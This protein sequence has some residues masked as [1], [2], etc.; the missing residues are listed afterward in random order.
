[1]GNRRVVGISGQVKQTYGDKGV[2]LPRAVR[3]IEQIKNVSVIVRGQLAGVCVK[4]LIAD[5]VDPH[6][7]RALALDII[8][9]GANVERGHAAGDDRASQRRF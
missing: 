7:R 4:D 3:G 6:V 1:M 8:G 9:L 5:L 2:G